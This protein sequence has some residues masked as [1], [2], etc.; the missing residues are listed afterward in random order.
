MNKKPAKGSIKQL[1]DLPATETPPLKIENV[2]R[3]LMDNNV[4]LSNI[5]DRR[6]KNAE[7]RDLDMV[8]HSSPVRRY[9][10]DRRIG[11]KDRRTA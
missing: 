3:R 6:I 2:R 5:P 4:G 9:T 7:R 10:I 1:A 8:S 11:I